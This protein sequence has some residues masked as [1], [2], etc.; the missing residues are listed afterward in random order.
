MVDYAKYIEIPQS[1]LVVV[2]P[3]MK[4]LQLAAI[5]TEPHDCGKITSDF[6]HLSHPTRISGQT[7]YMSR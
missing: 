2:A 4:P 6:R 1:D 3:Q 5:F 7:L